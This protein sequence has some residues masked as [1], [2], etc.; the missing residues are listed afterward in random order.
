MEEQVIEPIQKHNE[1]AKDIAV[2]VRELNTHKYYPKFFKNAFPSDKNV[3][4]PKNISKALAQY[5]RTIYVSPKPFEN[6]GFGNQ[7]GDK[8]PDSIRTSK[9][10]T[11][12]ASLAAMCSDCHASEFYGSKNGQLASNGINY[13][14]NDS[15]NN[16]QKFKAPSLINLAYTAPYMHDGRF[17][18]LYEVLDHYDKHIEE[19]NMYNPNIVQNKIKNRFSNT[20][21]TEMVNFLLSLKDTT[22]LVNKKYANPFTSEDFN[23]KDYPNFK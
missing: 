16:N 10:F 13:Y 17:K 19:L 3:I 7:Q 9:K 1:M 18:T 5:I 20:E 6:G 22:I 2:L 8:L 21:K 12:F 14:D 4:S 15:T 11:A 23:W